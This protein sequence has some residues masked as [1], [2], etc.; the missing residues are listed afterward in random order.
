VK[1]KT[2]LALAVLIPAL[3]TV[4][5]VVAACGGEATTTTAAVTTTAA[6]TTT[7]A[8]T[9][10]QAVTTTTQAVTTTTVALVPMSTAEICQWKTDAVAFADGFYGQYGDANATFP[11][12][13]ADVSFYDPCDGDFLTVGKEPI[14]S[15]IRDLSTGIPDF[16]AEVEGIYLSAGGATCQVAEAKLWPPWLAEPAD[17]PP[18]RLMQVFRFEDGLVASWDLLFSAA[19]LEMVQ[20]AVFAP[21]K[22]GSEQL[23]EIAD[24]YLGAWASG[25]KGRIAALYHAD[26]T[27]SDTVLGLQAQGADAIAELGE[28]RFGAGSP[29]TFEVIDFWVQTNGPA[30]PTDEL[31]KDGA[32]I[33]VGIHYRSNLVVDGKPS[34]VEGLTTF[35]LGTWTGNAFDP[36]PNG[37]ITREEVFYHTDSLLASGLLD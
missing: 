11:E 14:A 2:S 19:T 36:D 34:A 4:A 23:Q 37:L 20:V 32:I 16:G 21:G 22:G 1:S 18:A 17:H 7:M 35:E 15:M 27:F 33:G 6:P 13:A 26:A 5:L 28:K 12:L 24:R 9:A 3:L 10:T 31:P 30:P 29:V 8:V 25:D